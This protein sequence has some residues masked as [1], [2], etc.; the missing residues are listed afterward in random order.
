MK[1]TFLMLEATSLKEARQILWTLNDSCVDNCGR[2]YV[3]N[4]DIR[5]YVDAGILRWVSIPYEFKENEFPVSIWQRKFCLWSEPVFK[6]YRE[7]WGGSP[8][9]W[10]RDVIVLPT[11]ETIDSCTKE[12]DTFYDLLWADTPPTMENICKALK[13]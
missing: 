6:Y 4:S 10:G 7:T 12:F 1:T 13:I 9:S 11:G 5:K 3:E 2:T 8:S